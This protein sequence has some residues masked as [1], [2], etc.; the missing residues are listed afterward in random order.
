MKIIQIIALFFLVTLTSFSANTKI[1]T[2]TAYPSSLTVKSGEDFSVKV[3]FQIDKQHYTYSFKKQE[4]PDGI[5]PTQSEVKLVNTNLAK[6][7]G[8]IKA[9]K[10]HVKYDHGFEMNIEYYKDKFS[11][12]IPL[13]ALQD[14]DF[15][16]QQMKFSFVLQFCDSVS[17]LPP[18][19]YVV[20]V[21]NKPYKSTILSTTQKVEEEQINQQ[22]QATIE[23]ENEVNKESINETKV[24]SNT[25]N[26]NNGKQVTTKSQSEI[27][28]KKKEGVLSFIWFAM[29]A[30]ALALLTPCVFPM[31]PITVS[32]FTKRAEKEK[33]KGKAFRDSSI[34]ALG[35]I[36]TFTALGFLLALIFGA[37]GIRDFA[38]NAWVNLFIA[39]IFVAFAFNLFGAFE[40]QLPIGLL[41]V[42]NTKSNQSSGIM[43]LLLMSLTF[44]LTSFTCTVPFV[45]SALISASGGEWFYP[46]I[47]MLAFSA[48]FAAP[49]FLLALFPTLLKKMPKAGGWMNNVKIVMG[50]LEIAAAMKFLSNADLVLA[51]GILP[52]DLF[53]AIWVGIAFLITLYIIGVFRFPHDSDVES[54]GSLRAIFAMFFAGIGFYLM[55]GLFGKPLGELDAFLPPAEYSEIMSAANGVQNAGVITTNTSTQDTKETVWLDNLNNAFEIA[56][57]ENRNVFVDFSG[58]TC[59]NCRWVEQNYFKKPEII[60][61]LSKSVNVRLYTDRLE[62]PYLSNKK[63]QEEKFGSIELPLYVIMTPNGEVVATETFTRDYPKFLT[64]VKKVVNPLCCQ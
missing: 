28:T 6:I 27:E 60:D 11:I 46:I 30:G 21:S 42:L 18:D 61:L 48:V 19:N 51:L 34:Y 31:V 5:G 13:K 17:C 9:D 8:K 43:S 63:Y 3:D 10:P 47:G 57:K 4:T 2:M 14:I 59:T 41:N 49:F 50:F 35:I 56:K 15:S 38:S 7:S 29:S 54:V 37:T 58:F 16:K 62:E 52:K 55:V 32:F 22:D 64:F 53:V 26:V 44:S 33:A 40:I 45:G 20:T 1:V 12:E 23:K 24:E 25:E 36:L 39:A